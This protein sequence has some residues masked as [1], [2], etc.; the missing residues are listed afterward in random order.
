MSFHKAR[1]SSVVTLGQGVVSLTPHP[2]ATSSMHIDCRSDSRILLKTASGMRRRIKV[3]HKIHPWRISHVGLEDNCPGA[4]PGRC[5][6]RGGI[7]SV[8]PNELYRHAGF[9]E[10]GLADT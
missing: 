7:F 6:P 4:R 9:Y 1:I 3:I 5:G 10:T 8:D 2:S